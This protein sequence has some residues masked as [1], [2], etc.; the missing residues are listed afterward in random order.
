LVWPHLLGGAHWG[1]GLVS[2][3]LLGATQV[4]P[5]SIKCNWGFSPA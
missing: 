1:G 3:H 2:P 4:S 5:L